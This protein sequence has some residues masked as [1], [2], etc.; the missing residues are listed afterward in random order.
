MRLY[1]LRTML[2]IAAAVRS[3]VP[4][5]PALAASPTHSQ[6]P[7]SAPSPLVRAQKRWRQ[8]VLQKTQLR[9]GCYEASYPDPAWHAVKCVKAPTAPQANPAKFRPRVVGN[10][11]GDYA[12]VVAGMV[13][14]MTGSFDNVE[15]V[16]RL[17]GGPKSASNFALQMN[18]NQFNTPACKG[19]GCLGWTQFIYSN[20]GSVYIEYSLINY[21]PSCP[22]DWSPYTVGSIQVCYF[23]TPATQLPVQSAADLAKLTL[24]GT[25][26]SGGNDTVA[27]ATSLTKAYTASYSDNVLTLAGSWGGASAGGT[28]FNIVGDTGGSQTNLNPGSLISVRL[29]NNASSP[30]AAPTCQ[31]SGGTTAETNNLNL[32]NFCATNNQSIVFTEA[33]T[34]LIT[35]VT[36]TTGPATG[37]TSVRLTGTGFTGATGVTFS[38][39]VFP[40]TAVRFKIVSDTVITAVS[41]ACPP[42]TCETGPLGD[43]ITVKGPTGSGTARQGF[44]PV[45]VVTGIH[46]ASGPPG[47]VVTVSGNGFALTNRSFRFGDLAAANVNCPTNGNIRCT[48]TVPG[49]GSGS[50]PIT[51]TG[52]SSA[53]GAQFAYTGGPVSTC[54]LQVLGCPQGG[55]NQLYS[56]TC[57]VPHDFS[58]DQVFQ[59]TASLFTGQEASAHQTTGIQACLPKT[60]DCQQFATAATQICPIHPPVPPKPIPN[61]RPCIETGRQCVAV[62]GGFEC[63]GNA[64]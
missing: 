45:G 40:A 25:A 41:P 55:G 47:T 23:N 52:A 4:S 33:N 63:V 34:P 22:N 35:S 2:A 64:R 18:T 49:P 6:T 8:I 50:V 21:G 3:V 48:M 9:P 51:L 17:T 46:P 15:G 24:T 28:E 29:T 1:Q 56:V 19:A 7:A 37:G 61:C 31:T 57:G 54:A 12:A 36:P 58:V 14:S 59:K 62:S 11:S 42:T 27:L 26:T 60:S 20:T 32:D 16:T 30:Q 43:L 10:N 13:S 53:A 44:R 5:E 38:Q 39:G